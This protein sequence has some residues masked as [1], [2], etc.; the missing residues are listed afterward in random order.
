[1]P[2]RRSGFWTVLPFR[3]PAAPAA[4]EVR[5]ITEMGEQPLG[6]IDVVQREP[7]TANASGQIAICMATFDPNPSLLRAQLDSI[8]AQSDTN[9]VCLISD[10]HSIPERYADLEALVSGDPRF[11]VSRSERKLGFYRNFERALMMAPPEAELV[12][13][14][15]QDDIWYPEK[16]S[17]L[18][19]ALGSAVLVYSDQRLV[20]ADGNV[21][22]DTLWL[23]RSNNWTNL[24]SM[25]IANTITGAA[26][27]MRREVAERALPFPDTH[28]IE[29]HDHWIALVALAS[30]E[31]TYLD[32][33]LYDYVQH[34]GAVLGKV[35]GSAS[36]PGERRLL[37]ARAWRAAYFLGYMPGKVRAATLLLRCGDLLT[38]RKRRA[39]ER[40]LAIERSPIGLAWL[41]LRPLRALRGKTETVN[42]EWE[43]VPGII[44]RW[45]AALIA[46]VPGWPERL[47]L[48]TRFPDP[49]IFR[50]QRMQ[51]WRSQ[52]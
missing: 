29:F 1:M 21:L 32:Q 17:V 12:A 27:L 2:W 4:V 31:I 51:R 52:V 28:G 42:S 40:F 18:R 15:D 47:M 7:P 24:A 19:E 49:P 50:Q 36:R 13:L 26:A 33:P 48:D 6:T 8:R 3:A 37:R 22:R 44:W 39:L 34:G 41:V 14:S 46:R 30:G 23:G 35:A 45:L 5:A 38:P 16:L 25:L 20:D 9:W 10:D 43:L 11:V